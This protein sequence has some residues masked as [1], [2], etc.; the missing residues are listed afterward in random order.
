MLIDI[1]HKDTVLTLLQAGARVSTVNCMGKN[2][3][4]MGS[5]VGEFNILL[6]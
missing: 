6:G 3:I 2:V 4:Q 1:G 5:F